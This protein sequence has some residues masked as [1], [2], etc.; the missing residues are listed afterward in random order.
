MF[1][2]CDR[3]E[4]RVYAVGSRARTGARHSDQFGLAG[5]LAAGTGGDCSANTELA[6]LE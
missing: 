3:A 5:R 6:R 1:Q 2:K 4:L